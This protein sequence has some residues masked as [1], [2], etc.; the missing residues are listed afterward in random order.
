MHA[1]K[2]LVGLQSRMA[3]SAFSGWLSAVTQYCSGAFL[4]VCMLLCTGAAGRDSSSACLC[5]QLEAGLDCCESQS[6]SGPLITFP[7]VPVKLGCGKC[8]VPGG[9]CPII[10]FYAGR[11]AAGSSGGLYEAV[12]FLISEALS[13]GESFGPAVTL[14][15][16]E[17]RITPATVPIVPLP[18]FILAEDRPR[19]RS[20]R[21]LE[22]NLKLLFSPLFFFRGV[23]TS[24][25]QDIALQGSLSFPV[26]ICLHLQ[27]SPQRTF[28]M[29]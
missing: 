6:V 20:C 15:K 22:E 18:S 26:H 3:I 24:R 23:L 10:P 13:Q 12:A 25:K 27:S 4:S 14:L 28:G 1:R 11:L 29:M 2:V 16:W 8:S 9:L 17:S 7:L 5:S 19:D 21:S